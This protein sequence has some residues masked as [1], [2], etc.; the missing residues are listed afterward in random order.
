MDEISAKNRCYDFIRGRTQAVIA[1]V[2]LAGS[3]EAA[4]MDIAVTPDLEIIFETTN[5][6]RKFVNLQVHPA[7]ALVVGWE[8]S[9]TLQYEGIAEIPSGRALDEAIAHYLSVFPDKASHK[10]WPGNFYFRIQPAWVRFSDYAPPRKIE[11]YRFSPTGA[12]P[13]ISRSWWQ[14]LA[15]RAPQ[16]QH[17]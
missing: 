10:Y 2:G 9:E 5:Q 12:V 7:V 3:P 4:L 11:E 15:R 13:A 14:K 6:T 16:R 17:N 8:G 1:T